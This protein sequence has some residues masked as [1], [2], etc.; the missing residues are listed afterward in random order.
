MKSYTIALEE[1]DIDR[2][3]TLGKEMKI[4]HHVLARSILLRALDR[5]I[6]ELQK[7]GL[8]Q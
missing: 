5:E 1:I 4:P 2:L 8:S 3:K 6:V 7:K